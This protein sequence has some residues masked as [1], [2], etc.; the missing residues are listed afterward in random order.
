MER[1]P[2]ECCDLIGQYIATVTFRLIL[3]T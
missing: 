3:N 1:E 2:N